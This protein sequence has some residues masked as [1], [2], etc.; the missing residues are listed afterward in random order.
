MK[1]EYRLNGRMMLRS[2]PLVNMV[3]QV[4]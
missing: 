1:G 3:L 2:H 4:A